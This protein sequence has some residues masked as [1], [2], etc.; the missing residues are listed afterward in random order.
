MDDYKK[1]LEE[2]V[3]PLCQLQ[4][5]GQG[6]NVKHGYWPTLTKPAEKRGNVTWSNG[7]AEWVENGTAF[8]S[9]AFL[10]NCQ[11]LTSGRF[12]TK[13]RPPGKGWR[14]MACFSTRII[15]EILPVLAAAW[16]PYPTITASHQSK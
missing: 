14:A 11:K 1:G 10:G 13:A 12:G 8:L 9:V 16:T 2:R 3:P 4:G 5:R 6:V 7:F 15:L